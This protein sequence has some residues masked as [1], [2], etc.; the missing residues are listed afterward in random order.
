[1]KISGYNLI[2]MIFP[3]RCPVCGEIVLPQGALICETC[4]PKLSPVRQPTCRKCG[5]EVIG[6]RT[7]YCP[8]CMRHKRSFESGVA[9]FRYNEA[10]RK[11]MAAVKY[12]NKREY[13]DFYAAAA[14]YR[15]RRTAAAWRA[16][17][18]IPVPVH[19]SR[20][21]TRGFNQA[22]EFA[23]RL[24]KLWDVP[25]ETGVLV[26]SKKTVPQRELNPQE[27]LKNLQQAFTVRPERRT[28]GQKQAHG[29]G[30]CLR[31]ALKTVILIDDIYTTGSTMEACARALKEA[32]V[33]EIHFIVICIVGGR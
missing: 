32:G 15:F 17:A 5:K 12:K 33:S 19:V 24:G 25:V 1:M 22:E 21:R 14:D 6:E 10:A 28:Y 9:L 16:D 20:M 18:L 31:D 13:L 23:R 2:D 30:N 11:S 27:R 7:E 26:R 3:R 8:D 29:G 4:V